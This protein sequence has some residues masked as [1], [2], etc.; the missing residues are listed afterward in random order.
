[1]YEHLVLTAN[2]IADI[3]ML[4]DHR[5]HTG[6]LCLAFSKGIYIVLKFELHVWHGLCP[7]CWNALQGLCW[8]ESSRIRACHLKGGAGWNVEVLYIFGVCVCLCVNAM[9]LVLLLQTFHFSTDKS[10]Y[11]LLKEREIRFVSCSCN[12]I[13]KLVCV[14]MCTCM[15]VF[16]NQK[17][18]LAEGIGKGSL[19]FGCPQI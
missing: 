4:T 16:Q 15:Y 13:R 14:C 17:Q 9:L 1:M 5:T 7:E 2:T 19:R 18:G 6:Q 10:E 3:K 8:Q 12:K 11:L